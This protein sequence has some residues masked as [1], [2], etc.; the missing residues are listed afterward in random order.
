VTESPSKRGDDEAAPSAEQTAL[1]DATSAPSTSS[2]WAVFSE[3]RTR[4][5]V[6]LAEQSWSTFFRNVAIE[7]GVI[8][9]L[10]VVAYVVMTLV[11]R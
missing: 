10:L 11:R 9:L 5:R 1:A 3:M 4:K 2:R 6:D 8:A 7:A